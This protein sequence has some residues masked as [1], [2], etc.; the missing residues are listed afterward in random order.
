MFHLDPRRTNRS[1]FRAPRA[2]VVRR[3]TRLRGPIAAAP[4]VAGELTLAASLGG[5][6]VA[7]GADGRVA[8][9]H[10][11]RARV[12]GSPLV[13]GGLV[14]FGV[15]GGEVLALSTARGHV[16]WRA[17][18]EGDADTGAATLGGDALVLSAGRASYAWTKA[19]KQRWRHTSKKKRYAAPAVADDGLVV[20][21]GQDDH[22]VAVD[23]NGRESWS[24]DLGADVDC[25]PAIGDDGVIFAATDG[26]EVFAL[27]PATGRL[28]W[29]ARVPGRVRGGLSVARDG[30]VLVATLGPAPTVLA[31]D[32]RTGEVWLRHEVRGTGS[33]EQGVVGAPLESADGA[34]VFGTQSDEVIALDREGR[35]LWTFD[36]GA[37]VDLAV[38]LVADGALLV[39]TEAGELIELVDAPSPSSP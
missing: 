38:V 33:P 27:E 37:D 1:P 17:R 5:D 24:V 23:A 13:Q 2:P 19:G 7:L 14:I 10:D 4:A 8:W 22:L 12:Y 35:R 28:R 3:R 16:K 11:A 25:A 30:A 18:V 32:P 36:A 15:D 29:R 20:L 34:L 21:G 31:L 26:G 39:G 9:R 6:I